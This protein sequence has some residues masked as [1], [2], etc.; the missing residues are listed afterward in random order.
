M[1]ILLNAFVY[2]LQEQD[3]IDI[4]AEEAREKIKKKVMNA[5]GLKPKPKPRK[6]N[7]KAAVVESTAEPMDVSVGSTAESGQSLIFMALAVLLT[8]YVLNWVFLSFL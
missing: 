8:D 3:K 1:L 2:I 6:T 7:K 5:A 4:Q